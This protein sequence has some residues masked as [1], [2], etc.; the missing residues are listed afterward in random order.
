M[1]SKEVI[2]RRLEAFEEYML[3]QDVATLDVPVRVHNCLI[4]IPKCAMKNRNV[5]DLLGFTKEELLG[6]GNFGEKSLKD[7]NEY[8]RC[9][10]FSV[11]MFTR[12]RIV[13]IELE[14]KAKDKKK[15]NPY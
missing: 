9:F 13:E 5:K 8:L 10:G 1:G 14:R 2:K 12:D 15:E 7:L 6:L 11:W 4:K 3:W